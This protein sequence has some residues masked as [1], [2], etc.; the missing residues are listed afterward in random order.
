MLQDGLSVLF[1][2]TRSTLEVESVRE[3]SDAPPEACSLWGQVCALPAL[4]CCLRVGCVTVLPV[5]QGGEDPAGGR[6][7]HR[8]EPGHHTLPSCPALTDQPSGKLEKTFPF[9]PMTFYDNSYF[10]MK[11]EKRQERN[12]QMSQEGKKKIL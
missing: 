4:E 6:E 11:G 8:Q 12:S 2:A 7:A 3:G 9:S 1:M 5:D 10:Q